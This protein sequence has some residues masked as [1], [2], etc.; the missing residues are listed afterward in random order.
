[1]T[2]FGFTYIPG[3]TRCHKCGRVLRDE[4]P[5]PCSSCRNSLCGNCCEGAPVVG[6]DGGR[7]IP[8]HVEHEPGP[9]A[10]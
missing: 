8:A 2:S 7:T 5:R 6:R 3:T 4:N 10:A 9:E 1:M